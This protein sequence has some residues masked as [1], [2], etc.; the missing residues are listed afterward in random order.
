MPFSSI[1]PLHI[2]K[3]ICFNLLLRALRYCSTFQAYISEREKIRMALLLNRY[4]GKF[5]KQKFDRVFS[6]SNIVEALCSDNYETQRRKVLT[7]DTHENIPVDHSRKMFVHFTY[8]SN[9]RTFPRKFHTLWQKYFQ[10]S[11]IDDLTP[12]LGIRNVGN[13]QRRLVRTRPKITF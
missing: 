13:L 2:K 6:K 9:M 1:H 7:S 5:I 10:D 12:I 8:C 11:P 3:N 4:P